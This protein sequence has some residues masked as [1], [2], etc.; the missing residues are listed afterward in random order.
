MFFGETLRSVET[1]FGKQRFLK[2]GPERFGLYSFEEIF[3]DLFRGILISENENFEQSHSAENCKRGLFEIFKHSF[4]YQNIE[5]IERGCFGDIK[6][7]SEK[8]S[9]SRKMGRKSQNVLK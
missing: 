8:N 6:I 7:L 2:M 4:C 9:K 1:R 3:V 5:N